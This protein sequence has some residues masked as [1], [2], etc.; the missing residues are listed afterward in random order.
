MTNANSNTVETMINHVNPS[1]SPLVKPADVKAGKPSDKGKVAQENTIAKSALVLSLSARAEAD[2]IRLE[3]Q[4]ECSKAISEYFEVTDASL[5]AADDWQSHQ[6]KIE[7]ATQHVARAFADGILN[8]AFD[9]STARHKLGE[10]FGFEPSKAK[11]GKFTSKPVEPGNSIAKR[12]S[13]VTIAAEYAA[14]GELPD[15]GGD[16]LPLLGQDAINAILADFFSEDESERITVRAASERLEKAL[17]D[18]K[19]TLPFELNADKI[20]AFAGKIETASTT[21]MSHPELQSEYSLLFQV[22]GRM[23]GYSLET[24]DDTEIRFV[25]LPEI[26]E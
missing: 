24:A 15:R 18:V 1:N 25:K 23:F 13:A 4:A 9:R 10:A 5:V 7:T 26:A 16:N 14:T 12:V 2:R 6:T 17:R 11:A 21:I 3:A 19:E 8:N 22:L 20:N